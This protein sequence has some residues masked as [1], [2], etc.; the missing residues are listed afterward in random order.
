MKQI[1]KRILM[2]EDE[3]IRCPYWEQGRCTAVEYPL[4]C[5]YSSEFISCSKYLEMRVNEIE[6]KER[7]VDEERA[8][9]LITQLGKVFPKQMLQTDLRSQEEAKRIATGRLSD[10]QGG[11][12]I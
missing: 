4:K 5:S 9:Q 12:I 10:V 3:V 1:L 7:D 2:I 8:N 6:A 11:R